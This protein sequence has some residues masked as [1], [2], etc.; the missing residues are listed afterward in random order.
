MEVFDLQ[1]STDNDTLLLNGRAREPEEILQASPPWN[2]KFE[3][4]QYV[5]SLIPPKMKEL[6]DLHKRHILRP[7]L[8]ETETEETEIEQMS[9]E[10]TQLISK[11]HKNIDG[12]KS[13][14]SGGKQDL[15]GRD[16]G[17]DKAYFSFRK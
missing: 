9:H 12:L 3:E 15:F 5:L 2:D 8:S 14:L 13:Y 17:T 11:A 4:A 1:R 16:L 10:L 7:M 6:N